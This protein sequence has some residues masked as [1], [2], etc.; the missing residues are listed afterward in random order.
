MQQGSTELKGLKPG[1]WRVNVRSAQGGP[2][3]EAPGQDQE[4]EVRPGAVATA[5][6]E[7]E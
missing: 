5:T 4:V 6:F 1:R 3:G 7:V 2:G